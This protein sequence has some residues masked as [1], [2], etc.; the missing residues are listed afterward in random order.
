MLQVYSIHL[1]WFVLFQFGGN[2]V[3]QVYNVQQVKHRLNTTGMYIASSKVWPP[4]PSVLYWFSLS[5]TVLRVPAPHP[6][7]P[8]PTPLHPTPPPCPLSP[9]D[10][11]CHP[12]VPY[13]FFLFSLCLLFPTDSFCSPCAFCSLQILS[14]L[15]VPSV[16]YRFSLCPLS[17]TDSPCLQFWE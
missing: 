4:D 7:P 16:P 1:C 15:P 9:A 3:L 6:T 10:S 17:P 12:S 5:P 13:R 14:V 8:Y 11:P 2:D